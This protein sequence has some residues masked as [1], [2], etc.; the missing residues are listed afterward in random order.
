MLAHQGGWDDLIL[1]VLLVPALL[2][3]PAL[4]DWRKEKLGSRRVGSARR[5]SYCD[6]RIRPDDGRCM[7][8]G[9]RTRNARTMAR[10]E[11]TP[12]L[13]DDRP[14]FNPKR[15]CPTCG[16]VNPVELARCPACL[17]EIPPWD[18]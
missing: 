17:G 12:G 10:A 1:T 5:C 15:Y 4:R 8:C 3:F 13:P 7:R 11:R 2:A 16:R 6:A 18:G 14:L 9:F